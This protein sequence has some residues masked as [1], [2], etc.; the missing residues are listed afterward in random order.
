[1]D[2]TEIK[3]FIVLELGKRHKPDDIIKEVC[4]RAGM[5][6]ADA[7]KLV[8][9]VYAENRGEISSH[10]NGMVKWIAWAEIIGGAFISTGV[11]VGTFSGWIIFLLRLPV[12]YLGNIVYF[13][14]GIL[15]IIGG[16][17][18][19]EKTSQPKK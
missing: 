1:M 2:N 13:I 19:L 17:M 18:G 15:L 4:E 7:R 9:Q 8:Q 3:K 11:A 6:W 10:Q 5:N 16:I 14:L 12:P